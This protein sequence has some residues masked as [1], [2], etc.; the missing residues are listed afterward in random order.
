MFEKCDSSNRLNGLVFVLMTLTWKN[1]FINPN[2]E[3]GG[4]VKLPLITQLVNPGI[5]Q[6]SVT[7]Y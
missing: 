1:C 7:F 4:G 2:L 3:G 6:H 5:L